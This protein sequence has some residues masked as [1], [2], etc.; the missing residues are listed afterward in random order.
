MGHDPKRNITVIAW[1]NL[2]AA[3]DG[4]SSGGELAKAVQAELYPAATPTPEGESP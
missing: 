2:S 4:R 3:P 1:T